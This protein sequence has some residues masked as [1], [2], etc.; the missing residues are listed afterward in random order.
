[1]FVKH[2]VFLAAG[3]ILCLPIILGFV[4][5]A[6]QWINR[7]RIIRVV[8]QPSRC[9]RMIAP[10][11]W[12]GCWKQ[13]RSSWPRRSPERKRPGSSRPRRTACRSR[14]PASGGPVGYWGYWSPAAT[15]DC[16]FRDGTHSPLGSVSSHSLI[17]LS[18]MILKSRKILAGGTDNDPSRRTEN[19]YCHFVYTV[20]HCLTA[21]STN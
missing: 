16:P 2:V 14:R 17:F 13:P 12:F 20:A 9:E 6:W 10:E 19:K 4:D 11:W 18:S 21:R 8:T 5:H 7:Y 3:L 1:M 15:A